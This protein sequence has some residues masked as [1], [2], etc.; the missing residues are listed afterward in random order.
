MMSAVNDAVPDFSVDGLKQLSSDVPYV[1]LSMAPDMCPA[2]RRLRL[3]LYDRLKDF[4][5]I[6]LTPVPGC[7]VHVLH[8]IISNGVREENL[9]GDVHASCV[10]HKNVHHHNAMVAA[11]DLV[12]TPETFEYNT[13][14]LPDPAWRQHTAALLALSTG[15]AGVYYSPNKL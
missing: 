2:N 3:E 7:S 5:N 6:L 4:K 1:F 13:D 8:G 9:C 14:E 15:F 12:I 10:I 11:V